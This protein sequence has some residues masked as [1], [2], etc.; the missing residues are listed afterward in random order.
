M[1]IR[2]I[3]TASE[4][5]EARRLFR[6]YANS[7]SIDLCFQQFDAELLKLDSMYAF[8][9]G[10]IFL[11]Y[12]GTI[13][14]GCVGVRRLEEGI[15]ELKRMY[16]DPAY[17]GRHF[18]QA[19]MDHSLQLARSLG[20]QRIRL[21]TLRSM[22]PAIQLYRANGFEETTAYYHNPEADVL[23]FEKQF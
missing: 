18:G 8:P 5:D 20:Y 23:Y 19:L 6:A 15:A 10:G 1:E 12:D 16:I 13:A 21:D 11:L 22:L 9:L 4:Y 14:V 2:L 17:R 3:H 7:L